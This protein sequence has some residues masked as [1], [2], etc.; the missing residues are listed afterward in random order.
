M[1]CVCSCRH[2]LSGRA[3]VALDD[4]RNERLALFV[5]SKA[6]ISMAQLQGQIM[7]DRPPSD[8]YFCESAEAITVLVTAGYGISILPDFLVPDMPLLSKIPLTDVEPVSFGIYYRS[9]QGNP[10]LKA[11]I[12]CAKECFME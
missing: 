3:E 2:P 11:F 7:G 9:V 6:S 8:F 4:V 1:V 10:S 12:Q 5:P